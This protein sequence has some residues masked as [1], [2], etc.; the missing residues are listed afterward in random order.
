[1]TS[2]PLKHLNL[3]LLNIYVLL[4]LCSSLCEASWCGQVRSVR[5]ARSSYYRIRLRLLKEQGCWLHCE[6]SLFHH[7]GGPFVPSH[8]Q[9]LLKNESTSSS[10]QQ[11]DV[12]PCVGILY[13]DVAFTCRWCVRASRRL[14]ITCTT[15]YATREHPCRSLDW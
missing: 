5:V 9:R 1:M 11:T 4:A 2:G 7:S 14:T 13:S 6:Q 3:K 12:L 10:H 15:I 8:E